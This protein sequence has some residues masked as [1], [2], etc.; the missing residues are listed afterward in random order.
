MEITIRDYRDDDHK[1]CLALY[2]ELSQ[3]YADIYGD[4]AIA[5]GD[6]SR[7]LESLRKSNEYY[8]TWVAEADGEV[9]GLAGMLTNGEEGRIEPVIVSSSYR[10][11]GI[12]TRLVR[13]V[14][15]VA[16]GKNIRF[17]SIQPT[18]RNEKA[19][20]LY[21]RLGF[22]MLGHVELF[23]DLS[24]ESTRQWKSGIEIHGHKLDY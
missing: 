11:N 12:G 15:E 13:H 8:G 21:V 22:N 5:D 10:N 14:S 19:L 18:A 2:G 16:K 4:S 9:V 17:L 24:T 3:Y 6:S 1:S 23:Q 7:W 20:S